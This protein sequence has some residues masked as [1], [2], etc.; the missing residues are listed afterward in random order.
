MALTLNI[1]MTHNPFSYCKNPRRDMLGR[2]PIELIRHFNQPAHIHITGKDS[3]RCRVVVSLLHGNEPS[4]LNALFHLIQQEVEP[5]VDV[6]CFLPN[7]RA[8]LEEP[9]FTHRALPGS[10]DMNRCFKPPFDDDPGQIAK[11]LLETITALQPEAVID[12]HNTSGSG[13][14]F[15]VTTY[16]DDKHD[17]LVSLFTQ[18]VIVTD[19]QLGA[20]MEI[21]EPLCP[22]VTIECGGSEDEESTRMADEG[23]LKY[24]TYKHVLYGEHTDIALDFYHLPVR[25]ELSDKAN[26]ILGFGDLPG[27]Q[28]GLTLR[29]DIE[30][31]NFGEVSP[32]QYLG[33][34][35]E[36]D[37]SMLTAK[38]TSGE[39]KLFDYFQVI[40]GKLHPREKL[41]LFMITTKAAIARSDCLFYLVPARQ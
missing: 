32:K 27:Q 25:L 31:F 37:L 15:G 18:K 20:L 34:I 6:H 23:L 36:D 30:H 26:G 9:T 3:T 4:G 12:I 11:A 33:F 19:L 10:R 35:A 7:I 38:T 21:S 40:D 28:G 5:A 41:K 2:S 14:S 1:T 22:T 39:E 13:P 17:A 16:M 29:T 24:F 8:A